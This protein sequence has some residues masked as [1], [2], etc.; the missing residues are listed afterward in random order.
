MC[1][2]VLTKGRFRLVGLVE[3]ASDKGR[4]GWDLGLI[5]RLEIFIWCARNPK[6]FSFL[7][8]SCGGILQREM[9]VLRKPIPSASGTLSAGRKN[10]D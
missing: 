9:V 7:F 3:L 6:H 10:F 2:L 4:Q 1:S 8:P 5:K